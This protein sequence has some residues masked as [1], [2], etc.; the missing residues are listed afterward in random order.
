MSGGRADCSPKD[1]ELSLE[2]RGGTSLLGAAGAGAGAGGTYPIGEETRAQ[3]VREGVAR[4]RRRRARLAD[5]RLVELG[6]HVDEEDERREER[7]VGEGG[8]AKGE[9][10]KTNKVGDDGADDERMEHEPSQRPDRLFN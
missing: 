9:D 3:R 7:R 5:E 10:G 8:C 4:R 6:H 2:A 1:E